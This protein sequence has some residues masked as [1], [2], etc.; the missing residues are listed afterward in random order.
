M[1]PAYVEDMV[2]DD[3][4]PIIQITTETKIKPP[5]TSVNHPELGQ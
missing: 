4:Y 2:D 5:E 3:E 1:I